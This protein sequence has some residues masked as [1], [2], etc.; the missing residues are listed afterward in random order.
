MLG[1]L[2]QMFCAQFW[3]TESEH[4]AKPEI[5]STLEERF[6]DWLI[7]PTGTWGIGPI[8]NALIWMCYFAIPSQ[9]YL[10]TP[11]GIHAPLWTASGIP[12]LLLIE[13][14][15]SLINRDRRAQVCFQ[16]FYFS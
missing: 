8:L 3:K 11:T 4:I 12:I 9:W 16:M 10:A 15:Y 6:V 7:L 14:M 5:P 13:D 2:V 1:R